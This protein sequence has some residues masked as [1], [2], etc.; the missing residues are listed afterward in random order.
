MKRAVVIATL[1]LMAGL[2]IFLWSIKRDEREQNAVY[3]KWNEERRPLEVKKKKLERELSNLTVEYEADKQPKGTTQLLF[4][5][6]DERVY[7]VCYPT[8]KNFEFTGIL[9]LS[10][11][12]L[13]G[14]EGCI[15]V[16]QFRELIEAGWSICIQWEGKNSVNRWWPAMQSSLNELHVDAGSTIYFPKGSYEAGLDARVQQMGF[17]IVISEKA[18]N[19]N[20]LQTQH[21]DGIWHVGAIGFMTSQPKTW[22]REAVA[23]DANI[24]YLVSFQAEEQLYNEASFLGMMQAFDEYEV[25]GDL[26]VNNIDEARAHY[27]GRLDGVDPELEAKYQQDRAAIEEQIAEV[28]AKISEIDARYK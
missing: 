23:K 8:M 17:S 14:T 1:I 22:L 20:P 4:T 26:M 6:I 11:T 3:V 13:P 9:V 12:R 21:E 24:T 28:D 19:E 5:D 10:G 7:S 15:S 27:K 18:E 25:S 2:G 16:E